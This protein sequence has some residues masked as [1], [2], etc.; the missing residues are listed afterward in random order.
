MSDVYFEIWFRDAIEADE[1]R[2]DIIAAELFDFKDSSAYAYMKDL[3]GPARGWGF[4]DHE[5]GAMI[6]MTVGG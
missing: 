3:R 1:K 2:E 5:L 4:K 6:K